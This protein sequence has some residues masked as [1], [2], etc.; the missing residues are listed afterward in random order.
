MR[1]TMVRRISLFCVVLVSVVAIPQTAPRPISET[2][3]FRFVWVGDPQISPDGSRVA[4]VRVSV[5]DKKTGYETAIWQVPTSGNQPPVKLS[6][7]AH[8]SSPSWSPDGNWLLFVRG[9]EK[10]G[11]PEP[12]QLALLPMNGG[13]ARVVTNMPK[14]AGSP[15]WSP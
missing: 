11:K 3:L 13:E 7:G 2:D 10:E 6:S 12:T 14:G 4:F 15:A 1:P 9:Q 5:N 8:D